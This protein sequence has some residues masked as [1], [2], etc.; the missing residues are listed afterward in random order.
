[1][2]RSILI[3][4]LPSLQAA[5]HL[6]IIYYIIQPAKNLYVH[7]FPLRNPPDQSSPQVLQDTRCSCSRSRTHVLSGHNIQC[8][9]SSRQRARQW[10]GANP[11][12]HGHPQTVPSPPVFP[13]HSTLRKPLT[14]PL[15]QIPSGPISRRYTESPICAPTLHHITSK[16]YQH[17]SVGTW[18]SRKMHRRFYELPKNKMPMFWSHRD[19]NDDHY[20]VSSNHSLKITERITSAILSV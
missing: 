11:L 12:W 8:R 2:G 17:R 5:I 6:I 16:W 15:P 7:V 10:S 1:M 13:E 4:L 3:S 20:G 9:N 18:K 14:G 19:I